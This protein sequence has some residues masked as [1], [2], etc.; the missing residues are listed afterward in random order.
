MA[1][2]IKA[3]TDK[4]TNKV[5]YEGDIAKFTEKRL[6]ELVEAEFVEADAS[7]EKPAKAKKPAKAPQEAK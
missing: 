1:K 5:Y 4:Y 6:A 3:F 7:D 2:V